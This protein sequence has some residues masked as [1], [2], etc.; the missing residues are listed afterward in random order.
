MPLTKKLVDEISNLTNSI[1]VPAAEYEYLKKNQKRKRK[2][3]SGS[4]R[5]K[6]KLIKLNAVAGGGVATKGG[7]L[8]TNTKTSNQVPD[9]NEC[10][11]IT[12]KLAPHLQHS[13]HDDAGN[14][15]LN[16]TEIDTIAQDAK[17]MN[18]KYSLTMLA[19]LALLTVMIQRI[20]LLQ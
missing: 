6:R 15:V 14:L 19:Q 8:A 3:K 4:E 7:V 16:Q 2:R 5:R 12:L 17:D 1:M 10:D 11:D 20:L 18:P 9:Q 13:R